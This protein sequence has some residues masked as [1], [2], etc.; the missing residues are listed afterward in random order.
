VQ[1]GRR[2]VEKAKTVKMAAIFLVLNSFPPPLVVSAIHNTLHDLA[3]PTTMYYIIK[4][5]RATSRV[6]WLKYEDTD[7]SRAITALVLRV[8]K[9]VS[10]SSYFNQLTRLVAGEDFII[11]CRRESSRSYTMY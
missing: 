8:L 7:V 1:G 10:V 2:E 5:S 6:I 3:V 11:Q 4:S 9:S